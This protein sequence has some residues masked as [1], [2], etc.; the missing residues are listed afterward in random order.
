M[1]H[2]DSAYNTVKHVKV[3]ADSADKG[4]DGVERVKG[5]RC[6]SMSMYFSLYL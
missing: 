2:A 5:W 4:A 3:H 1:L 6:E